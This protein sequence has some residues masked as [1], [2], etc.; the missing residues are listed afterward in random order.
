MRELL[1]TRLRVKH[2]DHSRAR[3]A[4]SI[5]VAS[6]ERVASAA[7]GGVPAARQRTPPTNAE[8]M[9]CRADHE[10]RRKRATTRRALSMKYVNDDAANSKK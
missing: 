9:F 3:R 6:S 1:L 4:T 10:E 8:S 2:P 5:V 7:I